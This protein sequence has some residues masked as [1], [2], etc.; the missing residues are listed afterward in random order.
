MTSDDVVN[1]IQRGG[2]ILGTARSEEFKTIE[3]RKKAIQSLQENNIDGFICI[4]GDGSFT[5]ASI[6]GE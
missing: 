1:I 5:G 2:T 3:G 6:L 4:G